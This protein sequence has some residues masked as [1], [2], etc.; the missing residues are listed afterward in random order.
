MTAVA[1]H[2]TME[3]EAAHRSAIAAAAV[4]RMGGDAASGS[5]APL[6]ARQDVPGPGAGA[7]HTE[8]LPIA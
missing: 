2:T 8:L 4:T 6:A 3:H 7:A 5:V 1:V